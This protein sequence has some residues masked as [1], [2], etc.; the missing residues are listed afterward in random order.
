[1]VQISPGRFH[2]RK[3]T[4][5]DVAERPVIRRRV[6]IERGL[7]TVIRGSI[8]Y[9][10]AGKRAVKRKRDENVLEGK[11]RE[12]T[13]RRHAERASIKGAANGDARQ[14]MTTP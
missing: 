14:S 10:D 5:A 3:W 7:T 9:S 1:M 6:Y 12:A 8:S 4:S 11:R 2:V 13:R